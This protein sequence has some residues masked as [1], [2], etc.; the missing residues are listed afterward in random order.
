MTV[1]VL[2]NAGPIHRVGVTATKKG[3]GNKAHERNRA[4]RLLRESFRLSRVELDEVAE[5]Y[6]WVLNARRSLLRVRLE[7]PLEEFK[8]IVQSVGQ[9]QKGQIPSGG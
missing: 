9:A 3:V 4:K 2:P 7:K 1:F 6:D 8:K 5:R